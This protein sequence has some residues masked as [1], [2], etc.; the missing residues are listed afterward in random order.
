MSFLTTLTE[1]LKQR[2]EQRPEGSYST[3]L[4]DAGLDRILRKV[5]EESAEL[6]IAAK[7]SDTAELKNE[8]ADLLYHVLVLLQHKGLSINDITE[9]LEA[10]HSK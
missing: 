9:V 8:A 1:L 4:F 6:I 7:N 2:D 10:R 5:G 3:Q